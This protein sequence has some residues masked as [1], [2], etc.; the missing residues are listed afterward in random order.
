MLFVIFVFVPL[1]VVLLSLHTV[2]YLFIIC[3]LFVV[4]CLVF[5]VMMSLQRSGHV[6]TIECVMQFS[7]DCVSVAG[8]Y[9]TMIIHFGVFKS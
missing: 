4:I 6:F 2:F 5:F 8:V 1:Y 3:C 9:V 7:H